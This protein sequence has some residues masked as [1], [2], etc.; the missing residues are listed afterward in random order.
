MDGDLKFLVYDSLKK[1]YENRKREQTKK[2][3]RYEVPLE[4]FNGYNDLQIMGLMELRQGS[5]KHLEEELSE[6]RKQ[7]LKKYS[8]Y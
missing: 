5:L 2:N 7:L 1:R 3:E 8:Q 6:R 4:K